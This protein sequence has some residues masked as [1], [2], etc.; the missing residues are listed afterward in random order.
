[1]KN[2]ILVSLFCLSTV[3]YAQDK[4]EG[5]SVEVGRG[6]AQKYFQKRKASQGDTGEAGDKASGVSGSALGQPRH[7]TLQVGGFL[8]DRALDWAGSGVEEDIGLWHFGVGYRLGQWVNSMDLKLKIDLI[9]YKLDDF[10]LKLGTQMMITFPDVASGF[11]VYFGGGAGIGLF[12]Q[13]ANKE[14]FI[15]VD[16]SVVAGLRFLKLFGDFGGFV[17]IGVNNH[18]LVLSDGQFNGTLGSAGLTFNF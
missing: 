1:M 4:N 9:Q 2:T 18:F 6:A 8:G 14:S 11:P 16:Y 10:P 15:S 5:E 12:F 17:E 3:L 13:Q 7:M